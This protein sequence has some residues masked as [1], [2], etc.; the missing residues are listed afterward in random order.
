MKVI[1]TLIVSGSFFGFLGLSFDSAITLSTVLVLTSTPSLFNSS[2]IIS[3][4]F[5]PV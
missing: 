2:A 4:V 1:H 5:F 3:E